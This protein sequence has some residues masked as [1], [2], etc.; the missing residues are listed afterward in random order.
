MS[1]L[2]SEEVE[3]LVKEYKDLSA[4]QLALGK[5]NNIV[6]RLLPIAYF[7]GSRYRHL[8][9]EGEL[10]AVAAQGLVEALNSYS[11]ELGNKGFYLYAYRKAKN[12]V[13]RFIKK[14]SN[15]GMIK[16]SVATSPMPSVVVDNKE[17]ALALVSK[18]SYISG[19]DRE[20]VTDFLT[21]KRTLKEIAVVYDKDLSQIKKLILRYLHKAATSKGDYDGI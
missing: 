19:Q 14:Q 10:R 12:K 4:Q 15:T 2:F 17:K 8:H 6:R 16:S 18:L 20:I 9:E 21:D 3:Q 5:G 11:I 7:V 1:N 13:L